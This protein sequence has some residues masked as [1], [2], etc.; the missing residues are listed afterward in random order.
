M[1]PMAKKETISQI[2]RIPNHEPIRFFT[3]LHV[4]SEPLGSAPMMLLNPVGTNRSPFQ[5]E[6]EGWYPPSG[7]VDMAVSGQIGLGGGG[8]GWVVGWMWNEVMKQQKKMKA[9]GPGSRP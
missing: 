8:L 4:M 2:I 3:T 7:D 1:D 6:G 5:A 9:V